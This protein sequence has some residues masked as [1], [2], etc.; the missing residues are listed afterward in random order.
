M[1]LAAAGEFGLIARV[2]ARLGTAPTTL[3]GPGDDAAVVAAGDGRVV[4]S[5]DVLVEG[6]HFRTD[7]ASAVEIGHRAAA[8][9]FADVAAMG[10]VPTALLVAL[11]L[12]RDLD[13]RWVDQLADGLA[14]E[15]ETVGAAVVG[16]DISSSSVITIAVTALGDLRGPRPGVAVRRPGGRRRGD[17]GSDRAGGRGPHGAVPGLPLAEASGRGLSAACRAVRRRTGRGDPGRHLDDRHLRRSAGGYGPRR[18]GQQRGHRHTAQ[19]VRGD[20]GRWST[21]VRRSAWIPMCGC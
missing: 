3:V 20:P 14:A 13:A 11:C 4:V 16:G 6:R 2:T 19:C 9:N 10:A 17:G 18:G 21:R 15:C 1:T 5:T 7:W 12:P 8:A